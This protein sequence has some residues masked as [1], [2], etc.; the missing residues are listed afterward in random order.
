MTTR[1]HSDNSKFSAGLA[2]AAALTIFGSIGIFRRFVDLPSD[3]LAL[4]RGVLG[5]LTLFFILKVRGQKPD[6]SAIKKNL[7]ALLV[8]GVF[9]GIFWIFL[10]E[11][12]AKTTVAI[13]TLCFYMQPPMVVLLTPLVFKEKI[14]LKKG[15]CVLAAVIGMVFVSGLFESGIPSGNQLGGILS[16][17][18]AALFYAFVI[19]INKKLT[20]LTGFDRTFIQL[21]TAGVVVFIYMAFTGSLKAYPLTP[22]EIL[23]VLIIGIVHTGLAFLLLFRGIEGLPV[24][25]FALLS[26]I[27]PVTGILLG[28]LILHESLT[29]YG[30]IGMVLILGSTLVSE[31]F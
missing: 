14:T 27:E 22:M 12:Y 19:I 3:A 28:A 26:Y 7:R 24:L 30:I 31:L 16:G 10:F 25:T 8:S 29:V 2:A 20:G 6:L 5:S 4:C 23:F 13:A 18:G 15:L 11:A 21:M 17:L 1:G 9:M